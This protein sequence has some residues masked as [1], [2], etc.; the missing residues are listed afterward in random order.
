MPLFRQAYVLR[1]GAPRRHESPTR[2]GIEKMGVG[3]KVADLAD[4]HRFVTYGRNDVRAD[5]WNS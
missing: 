5:S 2:V 4:R 1:R 3:W